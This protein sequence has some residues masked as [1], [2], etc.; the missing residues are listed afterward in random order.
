MKS[1]EGMRAS[2]L[3]CQSEA[4]K[5]ALVPRFHQVPNITA[6]LASPKSPIYVPNSS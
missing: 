6:A 5:A 3:H 1:S 4:V 2:V